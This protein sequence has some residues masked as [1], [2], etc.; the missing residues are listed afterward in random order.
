MDVLIFRRQ[1]GTGITTEAPDQVLAWR[2][3]GH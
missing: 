1:R 3:P 2:K